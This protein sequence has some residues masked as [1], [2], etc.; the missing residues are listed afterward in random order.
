VLPRDHCLILRYTK[1]W[2]QISRIGASACDQC[3]FCTEF[4]RGTCSAIRSSRTRPCARWCSAWPAS[5]HHRHAVLLR[6]QPVHD[7]G[8]PGGPGPQERVHADKPADSKRRQSLGCRG[9]RG[10][11]RLHMGNRRVP[12]GRLIRKLGLSQFVNKGPMLEKERF[13]REARGA[14]AQTAC[15]GAAEAVVKVGDQVQCGRRDREGR[16]AASSGPC[17][18]RASPVK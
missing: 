7:D 9:Q 11:G 15:G 12:I 17:C 18:M 16:E 4:C 3:S 13:G 5:Q 2:P 1:T 14:A 8:L 10:A 6:V